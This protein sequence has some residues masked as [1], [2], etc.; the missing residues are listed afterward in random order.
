MSHTAAKYKL[1]N[2]KYKSD[3]L[4]VACHFLF[5]EVWFKKKMQAND[6]GGQRLEMYNDTLTYSR[7]KRRNV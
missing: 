1:S 3:L 2:H 5:E 6:T 7:L 4:F